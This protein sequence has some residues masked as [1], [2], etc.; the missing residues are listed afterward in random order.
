MSTPPHCDNALV[1]WLFDNRLCVCMGR[2]AHARLIGEESALDS[3]ADCGL[4]RISQPAADKRFGVECIFEDARECLG[5]VLDAACQDDEPADDVQKCH[6]RHHLLCDNRDSLDASRENREGQQGNDDPDQLFVEKRDCRMQGLANGIR[7]DHVADESQRD[8]H[9]ACEEDR[10][11]GAEE[12]RERPLYVID[13]PAK[14]FTVWKLDAR[15]LRQDRLRIDCGHAEDGDN[16]HPEDCAGA[17][18]KDCSG[19]ADDI[20]RAN[21]RRHGRA[22]G[23]E[24]ADAAVMAFPVQGDLANHLLEVLPVEEMALNQLCPD[25]EIYARAY[26]K[27]H[28]DIVRQIAVDSL[29]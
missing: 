3:L 4:Q 6:E 20:S 17:A 14:D 16:P 11:A 22:K 24:G 15:L 21:L 2:G 12:V 23:L 5:D 27:N 28:Q 10:Q 19:G 26:Q 9:R 25:C 8:N 18:R 1:V 13:R 7:L 29:D